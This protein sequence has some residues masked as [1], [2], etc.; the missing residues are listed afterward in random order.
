[1]NIRYM[2]CQINKRNEFYGKF[3]GSVDGKRTLCGKPCDDSRW[4]I[5]NNN[6]DGEFDCRKCVKMDKRLQ[7]LV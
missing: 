6:F 2:V 4:A 1:M 7:E 3:H 5:T